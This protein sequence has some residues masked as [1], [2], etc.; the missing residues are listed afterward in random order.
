MAGLCLFLSGWAQT[1]STG[2]NNTGNAED[3]IKIGSM[4]I[5]KK[6]NAETGNGT[7]VHFTIGIITDLRMSAPTG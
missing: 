6:G 2:K 3:T 4:I 5:I 1:D 7:E